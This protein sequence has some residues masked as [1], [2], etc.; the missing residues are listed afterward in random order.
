MILA[1]S[2]AHG[3]EPTGSDHEPPRSFS[4]SLPFRLS[5]NRE[6]K[7]PERMSLSQIKLQLELAMQDLAG[8]TVDL[9]RFKIRNAREVQALWLLRSDVHQIIS[10]RQSQQEAAQRINALLPCF[11]GWIPSKSLVR[12]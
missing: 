7:K 9:L 11:E 10:M 1:M 6:A 12:I 3:F 5:S 2:K 4:L 8:T